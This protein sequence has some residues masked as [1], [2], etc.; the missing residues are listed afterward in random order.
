[1]ILHPNFT[2][3]VVM[4]FRQLEEKR[5]EEEFRHEITKKMLSLSDLDAKIQSIEQEHNVSNR[6]IVS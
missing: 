4:Y 2:I 6:Y 3:N 5:K 1:M